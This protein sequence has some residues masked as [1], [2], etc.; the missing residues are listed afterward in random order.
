MIITVLFM[1]WHGSEACV[2]GESFFHIV[3]AGFAKRGR[4]MWEGDVPLPSVLVFTRGRGGGRQNTFS[5]IFSILLH[6]LNASP[7]PAKIPL[8]KVARFEYY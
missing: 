1:H 7:P 5:V 4:S 3:R 2:F 6:G 8:P